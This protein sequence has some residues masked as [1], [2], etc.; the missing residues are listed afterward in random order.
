MIAE[1]ARASLAGAVDDDFAN[2][3]MVLAL[4]RPLPR[5]AEADSS[6]TR[7]DSCGCRPTTFSASRCDILVGSAAQAAAGRQQRDCFQQIG[8]ASAVGPGEDDDG[9]LGFESE[10]A[11]VAEIV[12]RQAAEPQFRGMHLPVLTPALAS[13]HRGHPHRQDRQ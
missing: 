2:S 10:S 8:L 3:T 9:G 7:Y 12:E 6:T 5:R 4:R 13:A 1:C 11:I